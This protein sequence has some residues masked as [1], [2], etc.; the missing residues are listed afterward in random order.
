VVGQAH[1]YPV[2]QNPAHRTFHRGQGV[3]VHDTE[4][5][6]Q[7]FATGLVFGPSGQTFGHGVQKLHPAG[8]VRDNDRVPDAAQGDGLAL[9]QHELFG[10]CQ[11]RRR[12]VT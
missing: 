4:H 8:G 7:K 5:L 12:M 1:G 2:A 6:D 10:L 9:Q 3:F 11:N